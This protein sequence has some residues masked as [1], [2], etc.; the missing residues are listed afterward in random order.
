MIIIPQG[1]EV[2]ERLDKILANRFSNFSRNWIQKLIKQGAVFVNGKKADPDYRVKNADR[3]SFELT[4][5]P[6]KTEFPKPDA[7]I[8]FKVIHDEKDFAVIEKPS[9]LV[10]H[11]SDTVRWG[12]LANGLLHH[13]PQLEGVGED[14]LRPGIVHRLDRETS[15]LM[16]V[17][18]TQIG[19]NWLKKQFQSRLVNKKYLALL[20]GKTSK[21]KD[22]INAPVGRSA[23]DPLKQSVG[24]LKQAIT[25]Y[26]VVRRFNRFTLVEARPKTGRM[27]QLRVHFAYIGH[28][29]AGDP[30][31][32]SRRL[33]PPSGLKRLFL[34]AFYL[35]FSLPS[36][37]KKT[38]E[39]PL[40][41]ELETVLENLKKQEQATQKQKKP[42]KNKSKKSKKSRKC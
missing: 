25:F 26:E 1:F 30:V 10:V 23:S 19:F 8:K 31:Y 35:E 41:K 17:A 20:S 22:E 27:H 3:L 15:G 29:I 33:R 21:L 24:G 28:P 2:G 13:W 37:K 5:P 36:G 39:I 4:P 14:P 12:T 11:P 9:G 42:K 40:P 34:H 7:K 16:V 6:P 32:A 38:Y 18:K